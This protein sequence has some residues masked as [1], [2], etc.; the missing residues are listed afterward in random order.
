MAEPA[1]DLNPADVGPLLG[2]LSAPLAAVSTHAEGI[3]N[4]QIAVAVTAASIVPQRP[5]L[6]VQIYHTNFTHGLIVSSGVLAIN[7]L[8]VEQLPL[9]WKLGMHSGRDGNKLLD[10]PHTAGAT[11]SPL[12]DGCY[13]FLDCRVINAMDGGDMTAFLVEVVAGQTNGGQRMTWREAR[14][15]LPQHW[16]DQWDRKIAGEID[17]SLETMGGVDPAAWA[18]RLRA[19]PSQGGTMRP[20]PQ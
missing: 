5:R 10:V 14:P 1:P 9:I 7:F 19:R 4:A 13:G 18:G 16:A 6:I 12:V 17:V 8:D 15:R 3:S 11:G 2:G 20:T